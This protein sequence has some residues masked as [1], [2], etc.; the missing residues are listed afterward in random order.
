[1]QVLIKK[2]QSAASKHTRKG[3]H[4]GGEKRARADLCVAGWTQ[5]AFFFRQFT[6][7]YAWLQALL[8]VASVAVPITQHY[9][10]VLH[11]PL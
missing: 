6:S 3:W 11:H 2:M 7:V 10:I 9:V 1:M 8:M 5:P 4:R